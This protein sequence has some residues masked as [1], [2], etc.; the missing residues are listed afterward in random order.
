MTPEHEFESLYFIATVLPKVPKTFFTNSPV[1]PY[2]KIEGNP[3]L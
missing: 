3:E 2:G 1:I